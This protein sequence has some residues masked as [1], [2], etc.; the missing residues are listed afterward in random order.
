[1]PI[2]NLTSQLFANI[3]MNGFDQFM[4][5]ELKVKNYARY[6]DDFVIISD[7]SEYLE[8][9]LP[10]IRSFLKEK[11]L[12]ELHPKKVEIR[13]HTKGID[14]LGYVALPYHIALRTKTKRRMIRKL[15][16]RVV[17]YKDGRINENG[18][19]GSLNSYMGVLS[20]A[21]G[22]DLSLEMESRFWY[23]LT[24]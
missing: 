13:N 22:H 21:D 1:M 10:P 5:H 18:L 6:T 11:L 3:Y 12:L 23:W 14:F 4:K 15:R 17:E 9:I 19:F 7:N 20:H 8:K 2:G 24:E 16:E